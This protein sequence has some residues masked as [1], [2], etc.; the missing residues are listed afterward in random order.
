MG[1]LSIRTIQKLK[2]GQ[3]SRPV[4]KNIQGSNENKWKSLTVNYNP[5]ADIEVCS[6]FSFLVS[7]LTLKNHNLNV[8]SFK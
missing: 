4:L 6:L 8:Y 7:L 2:N 5:G 1:Q 3:M